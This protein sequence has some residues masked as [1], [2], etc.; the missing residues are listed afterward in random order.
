MCFRKIAVAK[1]L[2]EKWGGGMYQDFPSN[3]FCLTVPKIFVG[4]PFGF[5]L[6]SGI[7]KC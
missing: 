7:E 4:D 2:K 3:G 1:K 5:S 6:I